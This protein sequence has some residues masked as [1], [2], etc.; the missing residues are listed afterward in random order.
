MESKVGANKY[1]EKFDGFKNEII[2]F[3]RTIRKYK[4]D[5]YM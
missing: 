5:S 1:F 4:I 3:F 2:E